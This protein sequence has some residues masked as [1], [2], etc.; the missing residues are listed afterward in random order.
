MRRTRKFV[1]FG[2]GP[3]PLDRCIKHCTDGL[4]EGG[5]IVRQIGRY[6]EVRLW[7]VTCSDVRRYYFATEQGADAWAE[8]HGFTLTKSL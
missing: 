6:I 2:K 7:R 1:D 8:K 4:C 3:F 5:E